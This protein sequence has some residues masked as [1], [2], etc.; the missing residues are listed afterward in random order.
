M[1]LK[2][3][4]A[5]LSRTGTTS[6]HHAMEILGFKSLHHDTERLW[7]MVCRQNDK[8]DFRIFDDIDALSDLPAPIFLKEI[9][10]AYPS[11]KVVLTIRKTDDWWKSINNRFN[12]KPVKQPSRLGRYAMRKS[13]PW[14]PRMRFDMSREFKIQTRTLAYGSPFPNER[15]YRK[16]YESFNKQ[17]MSEI[18]NN[19]LLVMNICEGDGWDKLCPFVGAKHPYVNFPSS[20]TH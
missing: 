11:A 5:G 7:P 8:H 12:K 13:L 16:R 18:P 10:E 9:I 17:V 2:Y 19:Q 14:W 6:F 15:T 20:N 1:A 3:I 4:C